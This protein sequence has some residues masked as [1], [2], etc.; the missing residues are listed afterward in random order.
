MTGPVEERPGPTIADVVARM[1]ALSARWPAS[2]GVRAFNEMY[3]E[4]TR[5]VA[6]SLADRTFADR[7]FI[8]R[9]DVRFADLY[10]DALEAH[11]RDP[12]SAP[13]CWAA[14]I[15]ARDRPG[16][17]PLQ[18]ALAGMNAHISYDL[19]RALVA[20]VRDFGGDLD[21]AG[22]REDF[23][24]VN[25]VLARTQPIVK[26]ALLSGPFAALDEAMGEL[27]DHLGMW[28]IGTAR[29]AAWMSARALWGLGDSAMGRRYE[30][31]LDRMVE[32]SSR[33]L[34]SL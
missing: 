12:Q 11:E 15:E 16:T 21:D 23:V 32:A 10:F 26:A 28:A 6:A 25:G 2:D 29:E 20:T 33:V 5:Q 34:L 17:N 4:T 8:D 24:A 30:Q 1:D 27:D 9:L 19:P 18:F 14:L 7:E 22:R 3:L 13:R 31:G